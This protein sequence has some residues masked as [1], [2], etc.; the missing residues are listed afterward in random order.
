VRHA[1]PKDCLT[2]LEW[3]VVN[4]LRYQVVEEIPAFSKG[5]QEAL[6]AAYMQLK[7]F[8]KVAIDLAVFPRKEL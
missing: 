8:M 4:R 5:R 7:R 1:L 3:D 6:V 2:I